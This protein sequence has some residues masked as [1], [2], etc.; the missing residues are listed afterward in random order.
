MSFC[1]FIMPK[2]KRVRIAHRASDGEEA[3]G[4]VAARP[5]GRTVARGSRA[6]ATSGRNSP[7]T[8]VGFG[9]E[10][11]QEIAV[12]IEPALEAELPVPV[13]SNLT[14]SPGNVFN[15]NQPLALAS[16]HTDIGFNVSQ[17]IKNKIVN[18]QY[19][20]LA[21]L[22]E[23]QPAVDDS[24]RLELSST[25][26]LLLRPVHS[27]RTIHTIEVWTDAFLIYASIFLSVHSHRTNEILKYMANIRLAAIRHTG[28]GWKHYDQQF[29]LRVA[30][31][32]AGISF[33]QI[34]QELWLVYVGASTNSGTLFAPTVKK[35]FDFN[36]RSCVRSQCPFRHV[37]LTC[38]TAH[39][40]RR[41]TVSRGSGQFSRGAGP[42]RAAVSQGRGWFRP[43][44]RSAFGAG[45]K[46]SSKF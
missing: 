5:R 19:I 25:G 38:N 34:D 1:L 15:F 18:G 24:R 33:G 35:C 20:E 29:R 7:V 36:Y 14:Y 27:S 30:A 8:E 6:R 23:N 22:L 16:V 26:E 42:T 31:N 10:P 39:S 43:M 37:C 13:A 45:A 4:R 41:C 21:L 11:R 17:A 2:T 3:E 32:P 44:S 9:R 12:G 46:S 28:P 40:Y